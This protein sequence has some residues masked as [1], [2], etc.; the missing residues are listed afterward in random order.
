MSSFV[1]PSDAEID[2][3]GDRMHYYEVVR[4]LSRRSYQ[5]AQKDMIELLHGARDTTPWL[6]A[7]AIPLPA[8]EDTK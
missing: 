1:P 3:L 6:P 7:A 4:Y 8:Q 2:S 5:Q